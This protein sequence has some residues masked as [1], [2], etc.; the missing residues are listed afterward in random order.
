MVPLRTRGYY[1][2]MRNGGVRALTGLACVLAVFTVSVARDGVAI[3]S[4]GPP[5]V[6]ITSPSA[7]VTIVGTV[8][9]DATATATSGDYVTVIDIYD[10]VNEIG[11]MSCQQQQTCSG[12]VNWGATGLSGQH[13]LTATA[14]TNA[15]AHNTSAAIAVDVVTPPPTVTIT[16]PSAGSTVEGQ[17]SI[18][19]SSATDPRLHDYP[20]GVQ[21]YDGV[22]QIGSFGCQGQQTCQGAVQWNATG[23]TGTH[24]LSARVHTNAGASATSAIDVTVL[25]PG[26]TVTITAPNP[27]ARLGGDIRVRAS[28]ATNPTQ[29]DEPTSIGIYD[30][31]SQIG[32]F[33]CQGQ[34]TCAG[35]IVWNTAGL[36]GR[37]LLRAVITTNTGRSA[38]GAPVPVG[39]AIKH[40]VGGTCSL[41]TH[42]ARPHRAVRGSC[43]INRLPSGTKIAVQVRAGGGWSKVLSGHSGRGGSFKFTLHG[44]KRGS[45]NLYLRVY[46]TRTTKAVRFRIGLL[47]IV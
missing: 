17:I 42:L 35:S 7:G 40:S 30:G 2:A 43:T 23:L 1:P 45:F 8:P 44:S 16:S 12:S 31:T 36:T 10:G 19:V 21:V 29:V 26:P 18:E 37:H 47:Q 9:V 46:G 33:G 28:G 5:S 15:G 25:S 6:S 4:A 38:T 24:S 41:S 22:N 11:Q 3:A 13:T 14:Y 32:N 20:T 34:Q 39:V 27:G